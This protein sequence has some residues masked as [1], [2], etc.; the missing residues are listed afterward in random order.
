MRHYAYR[1]SKTALCGEPAPLGRPAVGVNDGR[2]D[3]RYDPDP[4]DLNAA[5]RDGVPV[6]ENCRKV[7]NQ[8]TGEQ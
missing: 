6:C 5:R 7:A 4:E 8:L 1:D 2:G 3:Y